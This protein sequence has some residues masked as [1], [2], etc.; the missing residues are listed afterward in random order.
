MLH[1]PCYQLIV[2]AHPEVFEEGRK[3]DNT[4]DHTIL[5]WLNHKEGEESVPT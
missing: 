1:P 5:Y 2:G 3:K 4:A